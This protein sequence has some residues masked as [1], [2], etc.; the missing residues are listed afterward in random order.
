MKLHRSL[1]AVAGTALLA[2]VASAADEQA[3]M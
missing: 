2:S 1:L 3:Q